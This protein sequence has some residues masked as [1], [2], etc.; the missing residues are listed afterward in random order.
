MTEKELYTF[1]PVNHQQWRDWLQKHH[2]KEKS[3]WLIYYKKKPNNER[4]TW[5]EAVDQALCFGW[6]DSL[7]KPLD[8]ERYMQFFTRRKANSVWSRINKEK[9]Q[10]LIDEGLM[11]K[12]GFD[13]IET[14]KQN[15][16]WSILDDAEALIIPADMEEELGKKTNA[17]NYFLS[18][19]K[20][21]KRNLLQWLV[22][23][24]RPET[25]QKRIMEIVE[26]ADQ[27]VK[28]KIIQWTKK[29]ADD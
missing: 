18:L 26:C 2:D 13:S 15:G 16:S 10:R 8:E 19:S 23:A 6:I 29:P 21:D 28:P 14:A 25:R 4:L 24:K 5:S 3:V 12:A 17:K 11:T 20:T 9:V 7:A 22:Q 1:C 27:N